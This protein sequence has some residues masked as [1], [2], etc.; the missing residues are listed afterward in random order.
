[1]EIRKIVFIGAGNLATNLAMELHTHSF[2][3]L[4]IYSRT[5]QS[6]KALADK[7]G[8]E[9]TDRIDDI[10]NDADIYIF[11]LKDS[12]LSSVL[13]QIKPNNGI[14]V[15]TAGSVPMDIFKPY[16]QQYGV[17]YPFQ[18]FSKDR[19]VDFSEIPFFIEAVTEDV[20]SVL[21]DFT[22]KISQRQIEL[23]SEKRKYVHLTGVF[24]CNFVNHL[25]AISEKI[26]SQE[27]IP[28]DTILP[29]INETAAKVNEMS[30]QKA[31]TGP[32]VRFDENIIHSHLSLI[33][34]KRQK[35]IYRLM[36]EDIY[37]ADK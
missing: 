8:C 1:M 33:D 16:T 5:M 22:G 25:Y 23:S 26:L 17:I 34:D 35:E 2:S 9:A 6:A 7:I 21:K 32:A 10:K 11:S 18:T 29:L 14:W 31:Q 15:H 19:R 28:F 12:A 27:G 24:A 37:F 3:I 20:L 13:S 36:S 4:Q 30:P